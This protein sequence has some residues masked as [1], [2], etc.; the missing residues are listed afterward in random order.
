[1]LMLGVNQLS[2]R[3]YASLREIVDGWRKN[4][5]AGGLDTVPF[6][7]IGRTM[8]PLFLLMPPLMELLPPL[9]L[10]FAAF[11]VATG[12]TVLVW[13]A[14]SCAATL[15]W[16]IVVYVT[17]RENPLYALLYPLGA[18]MLLYIFLSAVIR[19]RRVSWKGRTYISQ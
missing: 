11:G 4:V 1:V 17:V 10:V 3:M 13:A 8:F 18:L 14:I 2:T 16:W 19:G 6:G 7:R 15:I 9:A 12:P 5:F